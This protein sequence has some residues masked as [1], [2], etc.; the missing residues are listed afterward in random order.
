MKT[1]FTK[2]STCEFDAMKSKLSTELGLLS[3]AVAASALAMAFA[4]R[5]GWNL[6]GPNFQYA[7][8]CGLPGYMCCRLLSIVPV[9]KA[10]RSTTKFTGLLG[11]AAIIHYFYVALTASA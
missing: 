4:L 9:A 8:Y 5:S 11:V 1:S 2:A 6:S 10:V 3:F 7:L